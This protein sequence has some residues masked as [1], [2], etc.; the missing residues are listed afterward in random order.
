M[1][2]R[3]PELPPAFTLLSEVDA[4][5]VV[6]GNTTALGD[7]SELVMHLLVSQILDPD[8]KADNVDLAT[9]IAEQCRKWHDR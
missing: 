5:L 6:L 4:A 1:L 9:R 8:S 7:A 2:K 3:T